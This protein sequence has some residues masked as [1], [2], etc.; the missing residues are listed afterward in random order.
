MKQPTKSS[1]NKEKFIETLHEG[2]RQFSDT[3]ILMH[4]L[5]AQK[6]G[7]AGADHKYLNILSQ[8]QAMT[9]GELAQKT[10][11][12]TGAVTGVIDRLEKKGLA[13][14]K[15]DASDRRK[16]VI[17]VNH[18][19]AMKLLGPSF[20]KLQEKLSAL[21]NQYSEKELAIIVDFMTRSDQIMR[22]LIEELKR[23]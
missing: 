7:L 8:E 13:K 3:T 23:K 21:Y 19:K 20:Q 15:K 16:V 9:A 18:E 14:R 17:E 22:E 6:A 5:I 2:G 12:T 10:G 11:L 4:E 1:A